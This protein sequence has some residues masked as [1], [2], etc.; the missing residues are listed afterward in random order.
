MEIEDERKTVRRGE[1]QS[2]RR[3]K[4]VRAVT[5]ERVGGG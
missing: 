4:K 2:E 5:R 3:E 1:R